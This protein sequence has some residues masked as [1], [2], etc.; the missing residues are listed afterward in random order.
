MTTDIHTDTHHTDYEEYLID[1]SSNVRII[2]YDAA[3]GILS[4]AYMSL[5]KTTGTTVLT[6]YDY[7]DVPVATWR[8]LRLARHSGESIGSLVH[9]QIKQGGFKYARRGGI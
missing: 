9:Q 8:M 1:G 3:P 7:M 6:W 2:A 4:I 5:D